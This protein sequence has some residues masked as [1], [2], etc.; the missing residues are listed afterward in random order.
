MI[1]SAHDTPHLSF[2][3]PRAINT[4][5]Y[6]HML[7]CKAGQHSSPDTSAAV[8]QREGRRVTATV[9]V[10]SISSTAEQKPHLKHHDA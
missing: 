9:T 2:M 1:S 5:T 8:M 4:I 3:L 10:F 7:E 6:P